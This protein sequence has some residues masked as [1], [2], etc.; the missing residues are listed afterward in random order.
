MSNILVVGGAGYIGSHT[1]LSLSQRGYTPIVFDSL[2]NGH[3]EFVQWGPFEQ[4]DVRDRERLDQVIS[5]YKPVA[6]VHFAGLI[7]VSQSIGDPVAFFESNVSGSL[8]FLQPRSTLAS[9]SWCFPQ[10]AQPMESLGQSRSVKITRNRRS[11]RTAE[12]N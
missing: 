4:G 2:A 8:R 12:A 10:P 6:I 9:T 3:R 7:E 5:Y 11:T 1:C